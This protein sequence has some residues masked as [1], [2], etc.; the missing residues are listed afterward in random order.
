MGMAVQVEGLDDLR[1]ILG[2]GDEI[3]IV[4]ALLLQLFQ[5]VGEA[6][7]R[8]FLHAVGAAADGL[9]LAENA[10]QGAAAE[11]DGTAS[12]LAPVPADAGLF[13][14]V[15]HDFRY[16]HGTSRTAD[17]GGL[18]PVCA[19][20]AGTDCAFCK[21]E[22]HVSS[23]SVRSCIRRRICNMGRRSRDGT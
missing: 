11:K 10:F 4:R 13:P 5:N 1:D 23:A 19:A 16:T 8:I 21:V 20:F 17:T 14:A 6:A 15:K 2:R 9:V 22:G 3:Y 7:G 18:R 12:A